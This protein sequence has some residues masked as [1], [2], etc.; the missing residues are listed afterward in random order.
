MEFEVPI[1]GCVRDAKTDVGWGAEGGDSFGS[2]DA[3]S[4]EQMNAL[5]NK[6]SCVVLPDLDVEMEVV[7]VALELLAV[8]GC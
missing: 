2:V 5:G 8:C 4:V 1:G 7:C 6:S 3:G